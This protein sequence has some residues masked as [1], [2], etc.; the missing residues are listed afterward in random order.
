MVFTGSAFPGVENVERAK[1]S[2]RRLASRLGTSLHG[3]IVVP[4]L[5]EV[6]KCEITT[7]SASGASLAC[8]ASVPV[9]SF[10]MLEIQHEDSIGAVVMRCRAGEVGLRFVCGLDEALKTNVTLGSWIARALGTGNSLSDAL[11]ECKDLDWFDGEEL[12]FRTDRSVQINSKIVLGRFR[13]T[14]V[15][16]IPGGIV[17]RRHRT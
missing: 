9:Y 8:S 12:R 10:V 2:S 1:S 15:G 5:G 7:L 17:V 11:P 3:Q 13:G 14:V 4:S 16:F 6:F